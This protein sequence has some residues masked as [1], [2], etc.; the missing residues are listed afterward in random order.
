[1][2]TFISLSSEIAGEFGA[3]G[4]SNKKNPI[5]DNNAIIRTIIQSN[6][7]IRNFLVTLKLFLILMM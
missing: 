7:V 5:L 1:M 2:L 6:L 3:Q 4:N